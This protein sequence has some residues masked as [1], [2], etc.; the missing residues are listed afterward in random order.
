MPIVKE[1]PVYVD[2]D[3]VDEIPEDLEDPEDIPDPEEPLPGDND[4]FVF[5]DDIS[6]EEE[7]PQVIDVEEPEAPLVEEGKLEI[8]PTKEALEI[9]VPSLTIIAGMSDS[10]KT[11]L[12]KHF[13]RQHHHRFNRVICM[14]P[15]LDL[16]ESYDFLEPSYLIREP[17]EDHISALLEEQRQYPGLQTC[18]ILDDCI[19]SLKFK[20]QI[21]DKVASTGR[22]FR[23]T[24]FIV[25]Q[26]L[27][28]LTPTIRD[29]AKV[30]FITKLKQH[31]LECCFELSNGFNNHNEFNAYIQQ[32]CSEYRVV[33]FNLSANEKKTYLCFSPGICPPYFIRNRPRKDD[34]NKSTPM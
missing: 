3:V 1:Q 25:I 14:C 20:S 24:T 16:Q 9:I 15:T 6:D 4:D 23:L 18:L 28:K 22:H 11:N 33:R 21:F 27:K 5:A 34:K 29:N 12:I 26:D 13:I 7:E 19:G 30:M 32:A 17:T 10:G 2:A 8:T 31:S